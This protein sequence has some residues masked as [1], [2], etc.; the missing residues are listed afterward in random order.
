MSDFHGSSTAYLGRSDDEW[1]TTFVDAMRCD[2][3]ASAVESSVI[4]NVA[5]ESFGAS[6]SIRSLSPM[7]FPLSTGR[8]FYVDLACRLWHWF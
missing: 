5:E 6:R 3:S 4:N 2:R 8:L 1:Q 7:I